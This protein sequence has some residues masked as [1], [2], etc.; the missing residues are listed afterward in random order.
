MKISYNWLKQF[1]QLEHKPEEL[2]LILTDIGL[3]VES[4]EKVQS[5]PGGLE[6]LVIGKVITCE[7]HPNAD[8]L[9]VTTVNVGDEN[10]LKQIVCGAPNV[11]A[12]QTVV[13]ATV[14]TF[15]HPLEG[16][17]FKINK[18]K[19][20]GEVSEGM[21][22]AEDEI[23]LGKSHDGIMVLPDEVPA[24]T[25]AKEYFNL[26]D[27]FVIEIGLTPNRADAT[28]H[29]GV[30]RDLAA[31]FKTKGVMPAKIND[32]LEG[33]KDPIPVILESSACKRYSSVLIEGVKVEE[34]PEWLRNYLTCIGLR[35][36]NNVVDITNYVLH[37][38]GQ[39]LHAFDANKIAGNK[40]RV[41]QAQDQEVLITLDDVERKLSVEDLVICDENAPMCLAGVF[42]GQN[43]GVTEETQNV[44]L[45]SAY[46]DAVSIRKSSKRYGLKTDASFRF[47]RGTDPDMT[48]PALQYAAV[49]IQEIAGGKVTSKVSD[50]YPNPVKPFEFNVNLNR[51]RSLI[52][53]NIDN[54][55]IISI[56][57]SLEIEVDNVDADEI[58]VKVPA[59]R[60]DVTREVDIVEEVLRIFGYNNIELTSQFKASINTSPKPNQEVVQNQIAELLVN[61]GYFET[62]TNSLTKTEYAGENESSVKVLNPL[63]SDL[64]IMRT[65]MV[66]SLL[67]VIEYNQKRKASNLKFFEFG[68]TYQVIEDK[69]T[70]NNHLTLAVT[71]FEKSEHWSVKNE[72]ISFYHLKSA[73]DTILERLNI[74]DVEVEEANSPLLAYGI[75]YT[76]NG[77][78]VVSLGKVQDPLLK[79][80][81]VSDSVFVA[82]FQW[83]RVLKLIKKNR[84]IFKEVSKFP[85][86]K[87]DLA[88]LIN[89]DVKFKDLEKIAFRT[90]RKLLKQINIF[91]VYKGDKLPE[92]KK[93]YAL[94]FRLQDEEK[95]LS[96]K[97]IDAVINKLITNFEKE[98]GAEVRKQ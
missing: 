34:S 57:K 82:D 25:L 51:V 15:V 12:G 30:A 56:I 53:H 6:G 91:D 45:E 96:D 7:Q 83:D 61:N 8:R 18:S 67:E 38:L 11:Q 43:S 72:N 89:E 68:K 40:V 75:T 46:F 48:L 55:Q 50:I 17:P 94:S 69:Y 86:V 33:S 16:E 31:Y 36:I 49:L 20:R 97:Q 21:I 74:K 1:I 64:G 23:G 84:V 54:E 3:E 24:G 98:V 73:V 66:H 88:L 10:D 93:S 41:R 70:E 65:S 22:C 37:S 59:Y 4:I 63:S 9:R 87:R 85:S 5:I 76:K 14:G 42:G 60:V 81:D 44:F 79:K 13:V 95:T 2:G 90:E 19:I 80:M 35:P 29:W 47:E 58:A 92:G 32:F 52:G 28:S 78:E 39:P 26:E 77:Q 62:L 71:G 27:D